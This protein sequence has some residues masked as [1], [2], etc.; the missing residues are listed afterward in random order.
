MR[1]GLLSDKLRNKAMNVAADECIE[2]IHLN[3]KARVENLRMRGWSFSDIEQIQNY[4]NIKMAM[5]EAK[6][7]TD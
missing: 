1:K 5:R 3:G 2:G 4:V 7:A 6:E